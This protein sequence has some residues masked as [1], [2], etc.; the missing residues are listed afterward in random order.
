MKFQVLERIENYLVFKNMDM[1]NENIRNVIHC[2]ML[3]SV[4]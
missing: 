4:C 1:P 2:K 3:Q